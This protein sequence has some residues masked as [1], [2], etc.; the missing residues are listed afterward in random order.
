METFQSNFAQMI[1]VSVAI[2]ENVIK[3]RGQRSRS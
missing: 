2:V 3:V 1:N